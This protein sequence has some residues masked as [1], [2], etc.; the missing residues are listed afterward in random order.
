MIRPS[1]LLSACL[2]STVAASAERTNIVVLI[3]DDQGWAEPGCYGGGRIWSTPAIDRLAAGGLRWTNAYA[4]GPV[5]SPTRASLLTG[6]HPARLHLTNW[7][8]GR[9]MVANRPLQEPDWTRELPTSEVT[10]AQA[11]R[12]AGYV[13]AM[14]GKWHVS[15][16]TPT[17]FGFDQAILPNENGSPRW[18]SLDIEGPQ[19]C[20]RE[21]KDALFMDDVKVRMGLRWIAENQQRP[22]FLYV[23]F[24]AVHQPIDASPAMTQRYAGHPAPLYAGMQSH[25]D[26]AVG[27][28][29][30]GLEKLGLEGNTAVIYLSDNGA[31]SKNATGI[32]NRPLRGCKSTTYEG[33][34][35]VP[36]IMRIPGRTQPGS[37]SD[38]LVTTCDLYPT[39]L[40]LAGAPLRSQQHLDGVSLVPILAG[41]SKPSS[42]KR[43]AGIIRTTTRTRAA[44]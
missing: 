42:A 19:P 11:L 40:E 13:T 37:V 24:N 2:C 27:A 6:K 43:W 33:G 7:I 35:R 44:A 3:A 41:A 36:W 22:F 31:V 4:A 29:L 20:Q 28:M 8:P 15:S 38:A 17:A 32:E 5:C 10:V 39:L 30:D 23:G 26:E 12:E 14:V 1:T 34:I 16:A 21:A 18:F 9:G 25:L